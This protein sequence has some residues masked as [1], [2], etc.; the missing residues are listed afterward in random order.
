MIKKWLAIA[1]I[2]VLVPLFVMG[3]A[4][5]GTSIQRIYSG[6]VIALEDKAQTGETKSA[7]SIKPD[8][9]ASTGEEG[10]GQAGSDEYKGRLWVS[11]KPFQPYPT[12]EQLFADPSG[13][14]EI[15]GIKADSYG[16]GMEVYWR[17]NNWEFY[18]AGHCEQDGIRV[19]KEILEALKNK[20]D[21]IPGSVKGKIRAA[22]FGN[23]MFVTISWTYDDKIW[24]ELYDGKGS[25]E[26][27]VK[28]LEAA[29]K[30]RNPAILLNGEPFQNTA[31]LWDGKL[32]FPLRAVCEALGFE[33]QWSRKDNAVTVARDDKNMVL[34]LA[35]ASMKVD[36]GEVSLEGKCTIIDGSTYVEEGVF[37]DYLGIQVK[38]DEANRTATLLPEP[39]PLRFASVK[40]IQDVKIEQKSQIGNMMDSADVDGGTA[41]IYKKADDKEYWHGGYAGK[42]GFYDLGAVGNIMNSADDL[43]YVKVLQLYGKTLIKL[44]GVFGSHVLSANYFAMEDGVPKPF[45]SVDGLSTEMDINGDGKK[46]VVAELSG[47]IPSVNIFKSDGN[48]FSVASVDKA[49]GVESVIFNH[50]DG[51]FIAYYKANGQDNPDGIAYQYTVNGLELK[52]ADRDVGDILSENVIDYNGDASDE[53][54]VIRMVNGKQYEEMLPGPFMGWNWQ[55]KFVVQLMDT[56]GEVLSE[57]GLNKIFDPD[58]ADMIFNR[59]F[60]LQL[61]DYNNDGSPDFVIGQYGSSNGNLYRL[62]TIKNDKIE[63][64][65]VKTGEI[66]SSGGRSRY[67]T[68]FEK[69]AKSGFINWYYNNAEQRNIRQYFVWDG[70]QFVVK[71]GGEEDS[72]SG[73]ENDENTTSTQG[74]L[75]KDTKVLSTM[76]AAITA[77]INDTIVRN[78]L[79]C[80]KIDKYY[81]AL[82]RIRHYDPKSKEFNGASSNMI[83][84]FEDLGAKGVKMIASTSNEM[85][86]SP[87]FGAAFA[88]YGNYSI[89]YGNLNKSAW[90]PENDTRRDT[91]YS[92]MVIAYSDD[93]TSEESIEGQTGY[94]LISRLPEKIEG[95][96]LYDKDGKTTK[97]DQ[98]DMQYIKSLNAQTQFHNRNPDIPLNSVIS[99]SP[100]GRFIITTNIDKDAGQYQVLLYNSSDYSVAAAY[101][102]VGENFG[103]LWTEDSSKVCV[104]YSGRE[105]I[106]LSVIDMN[107]KTVV[108]IPSADGIIAELKVDGIKIEPLRDYRPDPYV[109]PVEWAPDNNRL[110]AFYEWTD[111]ND[112]RQNGFFVYD[113]QQKAITKVM[114]NPPAEGEHVPFNKPEGFKW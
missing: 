96:T 59:T 81:F 73:A 38:W 102:I 6:Q 111:K 28:M 60:L 12:E 31:E 55:G 42:D 106:D 92:K 16:N 68:E 97:D 34:N 4:F 37:S 98:C 47:T 57:I 32:F 65:P 44:Q 18:A 90:V 114:Q 19:A 64:L 87:G 43:T 21:L 22:Q 45:L 101:E 94:I 30:N 7:V 41:F 48:S 61:E 26:L 20:T 13:T 113:M 66:L 29:A 93:T 24:Y 107:S 2:A 1:G 58:G 54:V 86:Y 17:A 40:N 89:M 82:I 100:D 14:V 53:K 112:R 70:T 72:V 15:N 62:F 84:V 5:A 27:M 88:E 52:K 77:S 104:G 67:T 80:K 110:F 99:Q 10:P 91:N 108:K 50:E 3:T 36:G 74:E 51:S 56:K 103:F 76:E 69:F 33:V 11:Q 95:F 49:L 23:P 78:I 63:P 85:A 71:P 83:Y 35:A 8:N 46:E 105:W 9:G 39:I 109:I 79:V 75:I 25:A